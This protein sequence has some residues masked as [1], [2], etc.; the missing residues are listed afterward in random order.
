MLVNRCS[1]LSA[2]AAAV[3]LSIL[4]FVALSEARR[5]ADPATRPAPRTGWWPDY[6]AKQARE[7]QRADAQD[8]VQLLFLG[9]S[10]TE[11]WRGTDSSRPCNAQY[12]SSC[13]GMT[14]LFSRYFGQYSSSIQGVGGDQVM[15]LMWRLQNG[16]LPTQHQPRVVVLLIGT[17]DLGTVA[18]KRG[19]TGAVE[20][21]LRAAAPGV[22][23]RVQAVVALLRQRLPQ[24]QVVLLGL[25]PRGSGTAEGLP[26]WDNDHSWPSVYTEAT[27]AVN[28]QLRSFAAS[29]DGVHFLDCSDR[30]LTA[31]GTAI[32]AELMPDG[33]HPSKKGQERG[34]AQCMQPL[35]QQLMQG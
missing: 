24:S 12:R 10:I 16:A 34:L 14:D 22:A 18:Y 32:D 19:W 28:E 7:L 1:P 17:N 27:T 3:Y 5:A 2:R 29:Q 8:G 13:S 33:L 15:H 21:K 23:S 9:D 6:A 11:S 25:L 26:V 35:V 30:F 31:D 20:K 4:L